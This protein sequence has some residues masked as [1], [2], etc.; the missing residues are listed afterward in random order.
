MKPETSY[1]NSR[2][3]FYVETPDKKIFIEVKGV[4]LELDN[5][6]LFPDAP[7]ERAVKHVEE[8]TEA[9]ANGYETYV[10]FVIQMQDV[11]Y[12][13]PNRVMQSAFAEALIR[14]TEAGVHILA[15]DCSVEP[16]S[17]EIRNSVEVRL[18]EDEIF[19]KL[20]ITHPSSF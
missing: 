15:Y 1:G 4:T 5:V 16:D 8:L 12:F 17:M 19:A 7:S 9:A 10:L 18:G 6:V 2:F 14:A 13:V 3:D 11:N 20:P